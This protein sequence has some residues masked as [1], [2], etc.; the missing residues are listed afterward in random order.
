MK[1][2]AKNTTAVKPRSDT[3]V[4]DLKKLAEMEPSVTPGEAANL[5]NISRQRVRELMIK[6]KLDVI[7]FLGA[8]RI[9]LSSIIRRLE[10]RG[11]N[12]K[13]SRTVPSM[14]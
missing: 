9:L 6:G 13:N 2:T 4:P 8:R 3:G 1:Q 14:T 11:K 5:L 7:S 12:V 10:M